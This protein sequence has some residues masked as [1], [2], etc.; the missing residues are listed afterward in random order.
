MHLIAHRR[1]VDNRRDPKR[2]GKMKFWWR[3]FL[4]G[5]ALLAP[6]QAGLGQSASY[7]RVYKVDDGL[8]QSACVSVS[9]APNGKVLAVHRNRTFVTE[10]DGYS[11][12]RLPCRN[13]PRQ[14]SESPGGQ[15]WATVQNGL[16]QEVKPDTWVTHPV[17]EIAA[18][19]NILAPLH[20]ARQG[21]VLFLRDDQLMDF[22]VENPEHPQT[23]VLLR[24]DQTRLGKF[25]DMVAARDGGLWITGERGLGKA[26][27]L[28]NAWWSD[29]LPPE[30]LQIQNLREPR[31]DD[32]G[33]VTVVAESTAGGQAVVARFDGTGW[34]AQ[35]AGVEKIRRAWRSGNKALWVADIGC[36][37]SAGAGRDKSGARIRMFPPA[38]TTTWRWNPAAPSGWPLPP[39][40]FI[41]PRPSG[42]AP[43]RSQQLNSLVHCLAED[44]AG[45]ALVCRRRPAAFARKVKFTASL[46]CRNPRR[47]TRSP[48]ARCFRSRT[49]RCCW[50]RSKTRSGSI[51]IQARSAPASTSGTTSGT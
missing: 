19:F 43:A 26:S 31:E 4:L 40:C 46:R 39:A 38:S 21:H 3:I 10:L 13:R 2:T 33:G 15:L 47:T 51:R 37:A 45:P 48:S 30:S 7:W 44:D 27:K 6:A 8:H 49:G 17:P 12:S 29:Y 41:T 34:T 9:V 14:V 32:E 1:P 23:Q 16:L 22:N 42:A 50:T 36:P 35:P 24:C 25:T 5:T 28:D 18:E 20:P 11:V